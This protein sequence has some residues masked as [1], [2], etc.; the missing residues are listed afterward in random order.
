MGDRDG[1]W[2][3]TEMHPTR[4][5]EVKRVKL[6]RKRQRSERTPRRAPNEMGIC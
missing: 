5:R 1:G 2:E 3:R 6:E 4:E